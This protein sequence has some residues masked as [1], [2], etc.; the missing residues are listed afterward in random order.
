MEQALRCTMYPDVT[1]CLGEVSMFSALVSVPELPL[2][3][4]FML[5]R[6]LQLGHADLLLKSPPARQGIVISAHQDRTLP[7][8]LRVLTPYHTSVALPC[9]S[10]APFRIF[11]NCLSEEET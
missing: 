2:F 5:F 6:R 3:F 8:I 4:S 9:F 1:S 11:G 7:S 10:F